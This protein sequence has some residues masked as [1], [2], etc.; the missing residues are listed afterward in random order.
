MKILI[1]V[2][3]LLLYF[4]TS[5]QAQV[6]TV[7]ITLETQSDVDNFNVDYPSCA[8]LEGN[9]LITGDDITDISPLA[10]LDKVIGDL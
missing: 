4:T 7:N 1:P 9:L 8:E 10:Q 6:C 2:Y 5:G 3:I